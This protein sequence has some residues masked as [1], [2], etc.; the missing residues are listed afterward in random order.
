[1]KP[2]NRITLS[3]DPFCVVRDTARQRTIEER[4]AKISDVNNDGESASDSKIMQSS[5]DLP[6]DLKVELGQDQF[7]FL[8]LNSFEVAVKV[9]FAGN[10]R[11]E[12]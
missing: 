7:A 3:T 10:V 9:H 2:R 8:K 12:R 6:S 4:L 5:T 11:S 1:M